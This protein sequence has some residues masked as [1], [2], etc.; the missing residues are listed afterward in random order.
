[1]TALR[2]APSSGLYFAFYQASKRAM[3]E[4]NVG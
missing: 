3:N 1:M 2:D 4:N